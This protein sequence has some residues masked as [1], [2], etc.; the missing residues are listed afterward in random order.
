MTESRFNSCI[1]SMRSMPSIARPRDNYTVLGYVK[2]QNVMLFPASSGPVIWELWYCND[3]V[4]PLVKAEDILFYIKNDVGRFCTI[5]DKEYFVQNGV[6]IE[7]PKNQADRRML[8]AIQSYKKPE[9][10][11]YPIAT[12]ITFD[13]SIFEDQNDAIKRFF[14]K[15]LIPKV[16]ERGDIDF[17]FSDLSQNILRPSPPLTVDALD[18]IGEEI[19]LMCEEQVLQ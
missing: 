18:N 7:N 12:S 4:V 15:K 14:L 17:G 1:Y 9:F 13:K 5:K 11:F 3:S 2:T 16:L 10:T 19:A 6:I 8:F